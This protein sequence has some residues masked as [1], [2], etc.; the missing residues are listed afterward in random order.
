MSESS[1]A[2]RR[3]FKNMEERSYSYT[4]LDGQRLAVETKETSRGE[5]HGRDAFGNHLEANQVFEL[6]FSGLKGSTTL[7]NIIPA[8]IVER[9][10]L[11]AAR[12]EPAWGVSH[13]EN[14]IVVGRLSDPLTISA[15]L[16]EFGHAEQD[17]EERFASMKTW[18]H[19]HEREEGIILPSIIK[20]IAA[21]ADYLLSPAEI[22]KLNSLKTVTL[23]IHAKVK[24]L[25]LPTA[26]TAN[27]FGFNAELDKLCEERHR[28]LWQ[29]LRA[30]IIAAHCGLEIDANRRAKVWLKKLGDKIGVDF[31]TARFVI[32]EP[33]KEWR[34]T[35]QS[36]FLQQK[37]GNGAQDV[38][39]FDGFDR[40]ERS[41]MDIQARPLRSD[42]DRKAEMDA[43]LTIKT[44]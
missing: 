38:T 40:A 41:H 13:F 42:I 30:P 3:D 15:I 22:D 34:L 10:Q 4:S 6:T 8:E 21:S 11:L 33:D 23:A 19:P 39:I 1:P 43:W 25:N 17:T 12:E 14:E 18:Y 29:D 36:T 7:A 24:E 28:L 16:H 37:Y 44:N 5:V 9:N 26:L 27:V 35:A 31:A 32:P 20:Q 2:E